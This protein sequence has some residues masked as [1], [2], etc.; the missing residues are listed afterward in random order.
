[1]MAVSVVNGSL[2]AIGGYDGFGDLGSDFNT[3]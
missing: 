3:T 2:Y 1:M